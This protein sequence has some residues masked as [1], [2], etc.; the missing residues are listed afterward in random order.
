MWN[1]ISP[2]KDIFL[3]TY[4]SYFGIF[5]NFALDSLKF[6]SHFKKKMWFNMSISD[7]SKFPFEQV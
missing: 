2:K 7:K 4:K 1:L 5:L 3:G 6:V